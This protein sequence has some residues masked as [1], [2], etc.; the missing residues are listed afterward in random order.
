MDP[1][2]NYTEKIENKPANHIKYLTDFNDSTKNFLN[3]RC[4]ECIHKN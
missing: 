3:L 2:F 1:V 4:K